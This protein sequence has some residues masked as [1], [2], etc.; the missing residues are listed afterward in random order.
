MDGDKGAA[1]ELSGRVKEPEEAT[2]STVAETHH[3]HEALLQ[4]RF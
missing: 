3:A 2:E 4:G 1:L